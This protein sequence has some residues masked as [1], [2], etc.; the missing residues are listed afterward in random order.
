MKFKE[1]PG[2]P[3]NWIDFTDGRCPGLPVSLIPYDRKFLHSH[4]E[5]VKR[6]ACRFEKPVLGVIN[7]SSLRCM[8]AGES[9][10]QLRQ[11]NSVAVVAN[12]EAGIFG[13]A[14]SQFLKCLTAVKVCR[15]LAGHEINAVPVCWIQSPRS[16]RRSLCGS[17]RILDARSELHRLRIPPEDP[18]G[19]PFGPAVPFD[20]V[21][22]L[23]DQVEAIGGDAF[24]PEVLEMLK[25]FYTRDATWSSACAG[26]ISAL[27]D[28]WGIV[29]VDSEVA[30]FQAKAYTAFLPLL[31]RVSGTKHSREKGDDR[32]AQADIAALNNPET[33]Q[34]YYIQSCILPVFARIVDPCEL[35]SYMEAQPGFESIG[36]VPPISWPA[37]SA[38]VVDARRRKILKKY[39]IRIPDLL[40]GEEEV[41]RFISGTLAHSSIDAKLEDVKMAV[42]QHVADLAGP[43]MGNKSFRRAKER[44]RKH[45]VYQ[46][47]KMKNRIETTRKRKQEVMQR[48]I[49]RACGF[50]A[51]DGKRQEEGLAGVAFVLRYSR[52]I[53]SFLYE[54]LDI[55]RFEHQLIDLE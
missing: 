41:L 38:T 39:R 53:L 16:G 24:D 51:P 30:G 3:E 36:L 4:L 34:D 46:L 19:F 22:D 40:K 5:R 48:Q 14:L 47:D 32:S 49:R 43:G 18:G 12:I 25:V 37:S 42:E 10:R 15:E 54:N 8:P 17:V 1:L 2:T 6:H 9:I 35:S 50:L 23:I 21:S 31:H 20:Q 13:G 33:Q 44:S 26:L 45:V 7:E 55:M 28:E 11:S 27:M 52:S 29:S